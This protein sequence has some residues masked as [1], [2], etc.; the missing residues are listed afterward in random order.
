MS[1]RKTILQ[2]GG[3]LFS[4][5]GKLLLLRTRAGQLE[6]PGG[7]LE[8]GEAPET[9]L[10]RGF[11]ETTGIDV[12]ADRPLG[13]W[14]EVEQAGGVET[15]RVQIDYTVCSSGALLGVEIDSERH[16]GFMWLNQVAAAAQIGVPALRASVERAFAALARSR[17]SR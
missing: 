9:G 10:I 17:K 14:N 7:E 13:A 12:S 8:F 4:A 11:A 1:E 6:L 16:A 15:Y 3:A 2:V 5:E